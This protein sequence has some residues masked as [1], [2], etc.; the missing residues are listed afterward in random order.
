MT[1]GTSTPI[2]DLHAVAQRILELAGTPK[3]ARRRR[4]PRRRG[5]RA[6]GDARRPHHLAAES[7]R[8][9]AAA[10]GCSLNPDGRRGEPSRSSRSSAGRTSGSRRSS[11]GSSASARRSSR[12]APGPRAT[13]C[14]ARRTGTAGASS[15]STPA[16]SRSTRATRSRRGSRTRPGSRSPR[17]TSS[18]SWSRRSP[19]LTPAD[20]EA[21]EL[22]PSRQG[23]GPRR[24]EQERQREARARG[25]RVLRPRLG[26]DLPDRRDPRPRRR[27]PARRGRPGAAARDR[28][29]ARPQAARGGGRGSSRARSSRRPPRAARRRASI[30]DDGDGAT[31][32][33]ASTRGCRCDDAASTRRKWD[34]LIAS[35]SD[36]EPPAIALVGRPNVGKSSLLNA[37]LGQERMIVS[38]MPGTTRD[39]IDTRL[40][41]G[42]TR[43]RAHRYGGHPAARARGG[44]ARPPSATRRSG[45]FKAITRADVAVLADRCGRRPHRPGRAHRRAT[46]S[47]RAAGSSWPSTSGTPSRRRRARRSTSTSN[48]SAH[49]APF[50]DFAPVV[51]ISAK[52]GQR[53]DA[54]LE[55][56]V[57]V[58]AERRRR[59]PTG[60]L[61]RLLGNA[62]AR[63]EPPVVKGRRPKIFYATQAAS[64]RPRS[65]S[66]P[67]TPARSTSATGAT[68]RTAAR[69]VRLPRHADPARVPRAR[70]RPGATSAPAWAGCSARSAG[71]EQ[72]DRPAI[73]Q[74]VGGRRTATL[75]RPDD[76]HG[77][78]P[79]AR[80]AAAAGQRRHRS[81]PP[82]RRPHR[83]RRPGR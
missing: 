72:P 44:R 32:A 82:P 6:R 55:L 69:R 74:P 60:E 11:T 30:D 2:E 80:A 78:S 19:G 41:W 56:A 58:W 47:R 67:A 66:S 14:T 64:P 8:V 15:W 31:D 4:G 62:T 20:Q 16:A 22:P 42:R 43:D 76:P 40:P 29:G 27:R 38:D 18:C 77:R 70:H 52:T 10:S 45:R 28:G 49:E 83:I 65:C 61:N 57:D 73:Y 71:L 9:P 35:E 36:D 25:C 26:A 17:R 81:T 54:V 79:R 5:V 3:A 13:G 24:G 21:A 46:W 53:V 68:S 1:G 48:G 37:L 63:Q 59:V 39:A 7:P 23:A 34:A 12:T 50:L 75:E 51:S 33:T